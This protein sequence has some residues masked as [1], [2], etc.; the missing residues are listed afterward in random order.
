MDLHHRLVSLEDPSI[1]KQKKESLY[2]KGRRA[3]FM[4]VYVH[5]WV[6]RHDFPICKPFSSLLFSCKRSSAVFV[7]HV[8]WHFP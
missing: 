7:V 1:I 3:F 4:F 6:F 5:V 8:H 2:L